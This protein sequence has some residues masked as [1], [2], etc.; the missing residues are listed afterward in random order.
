[1]EHEHGALADRHACL[2]HLFTREQTRAEFLQGQVLELEGLRHE[3]E[4]LRGCM[5]S[6]SHLMQECQERHREL[7]REHHT[8]CN[9]LVTTAVVA[10]SLKGALE[11]VA[12][13]AREHEGEVHE[14]EQ[15][16]FFAAAKEE[17]ARENYLSRERDLTDRARETAV[18]A[19]GVVQGEVAKHI[20]DILILVDGAHGDVV[21][22]LT[23]IDEYSFLAQASE[24]RLR[25]RELEASALLGRLG[26]AQAELQRRDERILRLDLLAEAQMSQREM[27]S[28]S[29][30]QVSRTFWAWYVAAKS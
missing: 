25:A 7:L 20:Y 23:H 18:N 3:N 13:A 24:S 12:S 1:M 22:A 5:A 26:Q 16:L 19:L 6:M 17:R 15:K 10:R 27:Q 30:A 21:A 4:A 9:S 14:L 28:A 11:E 8:V 2:L 29:R